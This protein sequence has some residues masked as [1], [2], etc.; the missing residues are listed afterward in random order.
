MQI[1]SILNG[2]NTASKGI[3]QSLGRSGLVMAPNG[4]AL[5]HS[6]IAMLKKVTGIDFEWPVPEG[7]G[8]PA[9]AFDLASYRQEQLRTGVPIKD[10][11]LADLDI[12]TTSGRLIPGFA[13]AARSGM[14]PVAATHVVTEPAKPSG[15]AANDATS[16]HLYL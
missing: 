15:Q 12:L 16:R 8:A 1:N 10:L 3:S 13:A 7:K 6:D 14:P 11:T 9:A 2:A 5:T 4:G